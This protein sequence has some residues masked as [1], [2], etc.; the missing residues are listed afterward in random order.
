[1]C[2]YILYTHMCIYIYIYIY[3]YTYIHVYVC[4]NIYKHIYISILLCI[5]VH[6]YMEEFCPKSFLW[7]PLV[8]LS[9]AEGKAKV[10]D[11][12]VR[13]VRK[14]EMF[15]YAYLFGA[16]THMF[17]YAYSLELQHTTECEL[18][19][20]TECV[21]PERQVRRSHSDTG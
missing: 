10:Q 4:I 15:V 16:A 13:F 14:G 7:D 17:V 18:Q 2:I 21:R 1:M 11:R 19:H 5:Y 8:R 9:F 6:I 3:I 20:T 12:W